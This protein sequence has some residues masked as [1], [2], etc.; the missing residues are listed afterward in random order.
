MLQD[1][2]DPDWIAHAPH[3]DVMRALLD[4]G[5]RF[6]AL[7]KPA[8]L[9]AL[10]RFVQRHPQLPVV[11]DHAA[12]PP[13]A[14]ATDDAAF[15]AWR[16]ALAA[17]A[18][19]PQVLCKLSGLL[20]EAGATRELPLEPVVARLRPVWDELLRGFGVQRLM[21]GSDWPVLNLAAD[22]ARWVAVSDALVAE[23]APADRNAIRSTNAARFY[24][25]TL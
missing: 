1:L 2:P 12:K 18:A 5:L 6:D 19:Q 3:P 23:L 10:L 8:Q 4:L 7:V 21:W 13:L 25:L 16:R 14:A 15:A 24:A 17:L 22:Y 20:T 9:A 11:V